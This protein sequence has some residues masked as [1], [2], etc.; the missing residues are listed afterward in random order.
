M[1]IWGGIL[2]NWRVDLQISSAILLPEPASNPRL[3]L[4]ATSANFIVMNDNPRTHCSHTV[5]KLPESE[6]ITKTHLP[7]YFS[8]LNHVGHMFDSLEKRFSSRLYQP[9]NI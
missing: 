8:D 7:A 9:V 2:R 6:N 3:F 1:L 4:G 5:A